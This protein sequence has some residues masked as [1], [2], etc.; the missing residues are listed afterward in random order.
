MTDELRLPVWLIPQTG[1]LDKLIKRGI[2]IPSG[3]RATQ[4]PSTGIKTPASVMR[5][6]PIPD[7]H[8]KYG[9]KMGGV[10]S[11]KLFQLL[12]GGQGKVS[13]AIDGPDKSEDKKIKTEE[14]KRRLEASAAEKEEKKTSKMVLGVLVGIGYTLTK[15]PSILGGVLK[16]LG[17]GFLLILK[18][19]A[20]LLAM[21]LMPIARLVIDFALWLNE[22]AGGGPA[23]MLIAAVIG[24]IVASIGLLAI[25]VTGGL[26]SAAL[27]TLIT[28]TIASLALTLAGAKIATALTTLAVTAIGSTTL[29]GLLGTALIAAALAALI[30][31]A[32]GGTSTEA[33]VVGLGAAILSGLL[34]VFGAPFWA[35]VAAAVVTAVTGYA[36]IKGAYETGQSMGEEYRRDRGLAAIEMGIDTRDVTDMDV[37][38]YRNAHPKALGGPVSFGQSYLVGEEGPE[39]FTPNVGGNITP[40]NKLGGSQS[41]NINVSGIMD[42]MKITDL[43]KSIVNQAMRESNSVRG[44]TGY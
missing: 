11:D 14:K 33:L 20:D 6:P 7:I 30:V 18:P 3:I 39:L 25:A 26:I 1:E 29:V 41:I 44:S 13:R 17:I 4:D 24:L 15:V 35:A 32:I 27:T 22:L 19:F 34:I 16:M 31:V 9:G 42:E 36:L 40:N 8:A 12:G 23:G 21:I 38:R 5:M 43:I 28:K 37:V 10:G 2:R